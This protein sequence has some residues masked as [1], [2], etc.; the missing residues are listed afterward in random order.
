MSSIDAEIAEYK[1]RVEECR[2]KI[3]EIESGEG[4]YADVD[5]PSQLA[6]IKSKE[7]AIHDCE[8]A[9]LALRQQQQQQSK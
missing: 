7:D 5:K 4:F 2:A 1:L 9:I 8:A 3:K 6:A